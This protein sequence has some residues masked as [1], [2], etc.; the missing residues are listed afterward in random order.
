MKGRPFF[1]VRGG[2]NASTPPLRH[3]H[4]PIF[5]AHALTL[6]VESRVDCQDGP[7]VSREQIQ[8]K[9]FRSTFRKTITLPDNSPYSAHLSERMQVPPGICRAEFRK[10]RQLNASLWLRRCVRSN[11]SNDC[12]DCSGP[13]IRSSGRAATSALL[14]QYPSRVYSVV[15]SGRKWVPMGNLYHAS[16]R[17]ACSNPR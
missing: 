8:P 9:S 10:F 15:M 6:A 13:K 14:N 12:S 17:H 1:P 11:F 3:D 16:H 5:D 7:L 2:D 4:S